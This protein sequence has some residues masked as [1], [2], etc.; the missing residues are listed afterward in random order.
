MGRAEG[1]R[2]RERERKRERERERESQVGSISIVEPNKG[3]DSMTW[4]HN[5]S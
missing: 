1:G 3:L 4:D 5:S 2:E